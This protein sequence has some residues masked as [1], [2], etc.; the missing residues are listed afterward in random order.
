[1]SKSYVPDHPDLNLCPECGSFFAP[2]AEHCPICG[3]L[4]P[5]EMRAG[6]RAVKK[7]KDPTAKEFW[8]QGRGASRVRFVEWYHSW[9]F[10]I[11]MLFWMPIVGLVLLITSPHKP[12]W[13]AVL[14]AAAVLYTIL[15]TF[16]IGNLIGHVTGMFEKPVDTSLSRDA[17]IAQCET[18]E[19]DAEAFYRMPDAY[20]DR[21]CSLQL[22]VKEK[23]TDPETQYNGDKYGEYYLCTDESGAFTILVRD[24]TALTGE[25][26][27][28]VSGDVITVFGEGA[29][30]VSVC[31]TEY[32]RIDAPCI[33]MAYAAL[34]K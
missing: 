34:A 13:K 16:G 22:T 21:M 10:I 6:N 32:Q 31:N 26:Q 20:L 25:T 17:Y 27:N 9:W 5:E 28:F 29:G 12:K 1:M 30:N 4:C 2:S 3:A 11:L 18:L 33:H 15:S 8:S 14:I 24:C 19:T 7:Q 23:F